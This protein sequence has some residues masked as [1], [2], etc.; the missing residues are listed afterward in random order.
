MLEK[1][2]Y[3]LEDNIL[4]DI[5]EV[6][7]QKKV[8]PKDFLSAFL[9]SEDNNFKKSDKGNQVLMSKDK[10]SERGKP[11]YEFLHKTQMEYL[12][13]AF[14]TNS[15]NNKN[16]KENRSLRDIANLHK[17]WK[18]YQEVIKY[19]T[20]HMAS[21]EILQRNERELIDLI[22]KAEV[23]NT[24]FNFWW[25]IVAESHPIIR[26]QDKTS[27]D[28]VNHPEVKRIITKEKL[29]KENWILD[30]TN[31][32]SGL[33]LL[34]CT[35]VFL[36]SLQIKISR[37][38]HKIPFFLEEMQGVGEHRKYRVKLYLFSRD[39]TSDIF[40]DSVMSWSILEHFEGSLQEQHNFSGCNE[41]KNICVTVTTLEA[42]QSLCDMPKCVRTLRVTL[43]LPPE[44]NPADVPYL[45][46]SGNLEVNLVDLTNER[47]PWVLEVLKKMVDSDGCW[48]L[49]LQFYEVTF[50][51]IR[52]LVK[53]LKYIVADKLSIKC[54]D[55]PDMEDQEAL[56]SN[57]HVIDVKHCEIKRS[58]VNF[59]PFIT[60]G[61]IALEGGP[62]KEIV[63]LRDTGA[64]L[65][66]V[67]KS[68]LEWMA[69]SFSGEEV[70]VRGLDSGLT[71]PLHYFN[72]ETGFISEELPICGVDMLL[73]NDLAGDRV[74]PEPIMINN[75]L[76]CDVDNI[77][78]VPITD[79]IHTSSDDVVKGEAVATD[80][81]PACVIT[82]AMAKDEDIFADEMNFDELFMKDEKC[83]EDETNTDKVELKGNFNPDFLVDKEELI[84]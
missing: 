65:S 48:R 53:K 49:S 78:N 74:V 15:L 18:N 6:C 69:E 59:E 39:Q 19:L 56:Q 66:L 45:N 58:N 1:E 25:N 31:V 44:C 35:R 7:A 24:D 55:M 33:K 82:R 57:T 51:D 21:Q 20:G 11:I 38:P 71:I 40:L 75:P 68:A 54:R 52:L 42:L 43:K 8:D 79:V 72:I 84:R 62:E 10:K 32:V 12:A 13:A 23:K 67:L 14:L 3:I 2:L 29:Q 9:M 81:F 73:G 83:N 17:C 36:R 64:N 70:R 41:L 47:M 26:R 46:Y 60:E 4:N 61:K 76:E 30:D 37:N 27:Y 22:D 80:V 34:K 28:T 5:S 77:V 16:Q 50:K 63:V